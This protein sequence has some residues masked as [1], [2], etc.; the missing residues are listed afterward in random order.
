M[1]DFFISSLNSCR[2][3]AMACVSANDLPVHSAMLSAQHRGVDRQVTCLLLLL[4]L[5]SIMCIGGMRLY[6]V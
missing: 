4:L 5:L 6:L 1:T 3:C 2:L